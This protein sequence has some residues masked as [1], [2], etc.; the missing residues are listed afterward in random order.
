MMT[1]SN[2]N[3][4]VLLSLCAGNSPVTGEFSAQRPVTQ[5]FGVCF[6]GQRM[7]LQ[8][9]KGN[10]RLETQLHNVMSYKMRIV[11]NSWGRIY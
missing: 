4:S 5:S 8:L 6:F 1:S 10:R 3:I 9:N 11:I 2:G 7:N